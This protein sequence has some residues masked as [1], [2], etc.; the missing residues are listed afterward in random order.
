MNKS[1]K[2]AAYTLLDVCADISDDVVA[3]IS[4][5]DDVL[6]VTLIK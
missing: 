6:H 4:A 3:K 1:K 2:D 5:L